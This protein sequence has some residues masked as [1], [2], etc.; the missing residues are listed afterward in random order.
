MNTS[1]KISSRFKKK[2]KPKFKN[3]ELYNDLDIPLYN[4]EQLLKHGDMKFLFVNEKERNY[5]VNPNRIIEAYDSI[6]DKYMQKLDIDLMNDELYILMQHC[7]Q[8]NEDRIQGDRTQINFIK[9]YEQQ[10]EDIKKESLKADFSKQRMAVEKWAKYNIDPKEKTLNDFCNLVLMM[11]EE[12]EQI[13][14][15]KNSRHG[16]NTED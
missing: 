13:I 2:S 7:I 4:W 5:H 14:E 16:G 6:S 9:M 3:F 11:R 15:N 10:I 8:A 12:T 1:K